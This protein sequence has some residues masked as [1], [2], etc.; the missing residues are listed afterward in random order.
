MV[1]IHSRILGH[2][3]VPA[4]ALRSPLPRVAGWGCVGLHGTSCLHRATTPGVDCRSLDILFVQ[5]LGLRE[6]YTSSKTDS[7]LTLGHRSERFCILCCDSSSNHH[8]YPRNKY[9]NLVTVGNDAQWFR[10]FTCQLYRSG[11][12]NHSRAYS[13]TSILRLNFSLTDN[14]LTRSTTSR[15]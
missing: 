7:S 5:D 12:H 9:F 14:N 2:C 1:V 13:V 15:I 11:L 10:Q 3:G 8:V 4:G 6:V